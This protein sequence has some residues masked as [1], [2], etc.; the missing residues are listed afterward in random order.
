M[1]DP[2]IWKE[3]A[4]KTIEVAVERALDAGRSIDDIEGYVRGM[5]C[6]FNDK[7]PDSLGSEYDRGAQLAHRVWLDELDARFAPGRRRRE[8]RP[9]PF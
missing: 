1:I 7:R 6:P 4:S 5:I 9:P 8:R 3:R 2:K